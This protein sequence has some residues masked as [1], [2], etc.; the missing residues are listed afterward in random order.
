M[1]FATISDEE[2]LDRALDLFRTYG[3]EGVSLSRLSAAAGL[4]KASLY[5]RFP[6]GKEEIA[7]AVGNRVIEWFQQNV[8]ASLQGEGAPRKRVALVAEHL[9]SFYQDGRKSCIC[10]VLSIPG[11][12]EALHSTIQGAMQAW[13]HSFAEIARESGFSPAMARSRAEEAVLRIEGSLVIAR[14]LGEASQFKRTLKS[15]PD[16]LTEA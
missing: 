2:F 1:A 12:S 8:F 16:F 6:G 4:E 10:D 13:I 9:R 3:F 15:L 14:V 5:Y 11:G 7:M